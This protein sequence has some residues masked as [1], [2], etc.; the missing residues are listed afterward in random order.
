[1]PI[2]TVGNARNQ[3]SQLLWDET[4]TSS[5][6]DWGL[7]FLWPGP[8]L[9][10]LEA[11]KTWKPSKRRSLLKPGRICVLVVIE[12]WK[13]LSSGSIRE[14]EASKNWEHPRTG[15]IQEL[16][17]SKI[18]FCFVIQG[19]GWNLTEKASGLSCSSTPMPCGQKFYNKG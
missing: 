11:F 7:A 14:L 19:H 15:S 10:S 9:P 13:H 5:L 12:I 1:M 3:N 16:E 4:D 17:A 6:Q 8:S 18:H 2:R